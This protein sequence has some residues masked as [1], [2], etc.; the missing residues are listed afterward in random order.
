MPPPEL[1]AVAFAKG[2]DGDEHFEGINDT[3]S[4]SIIHRVGK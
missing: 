1:P 4:V 2:G 3:A